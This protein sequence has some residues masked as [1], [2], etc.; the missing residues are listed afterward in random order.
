MASVEMTPDELR[1]SPQSFGDQVDDFSRETMLAAEADLP[2]VYQDARALSETG[3]MSPKNERLV[4]SSY[5]TQ[6]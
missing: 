1:I 4:R 5:A 6:R 2:P 3:G